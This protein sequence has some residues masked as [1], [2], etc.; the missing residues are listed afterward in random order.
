MRK[1][2]QFATTRWSVVLLAAKPDGDDAH[3]A[4][5]ALCRTYWFPL[6]AHERRRGLA[7]HDAEDL[8]HEFF[9]RL[10]LIGQGGMG[11]V[12]R[13]R[14]PAL[15]RFVALKILP[16]QTGR[17]PAFAERFTREARHSRS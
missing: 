10:R 8:T 1:D 7:A 17:E 4:L 9:A 3:A 2:A 5:T 11:A 6:Y 15:D 12:Y 14:Q 13:A 16:P